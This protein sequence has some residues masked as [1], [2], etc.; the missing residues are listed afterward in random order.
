MKDDV[1]QCLGLG[2]LIVDDTSDFDSN[3]VDGM[4]RRFIDFHLRETTLISTWAVYCDASWCDAIM[5]ALTSLARVADV[6]GSRQTGLAPGDPELDMTDEPPKVQSVLM[7]EPLRRRASRL[8][9]QDTR[10]DRLRPKKN[11]LL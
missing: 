1:S 4:R 2:L 8:K 9:S 11:L 7:R 10:R 6:T 5:N 3:Q